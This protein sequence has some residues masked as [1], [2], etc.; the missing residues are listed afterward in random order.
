MNLSEF[1]IKIK[2]SLQLIRCNISKQTAD[3]LDVP[4]DTMLSPLSL[5]HNNNHV[6]SLPQHT[7]A[8][9]KLPNFIEIMSS[10]KSRQSSNGSNVDTVPSDTIP[11]D[12]SH[13]ETESNPIA[14]ETN[15]TYETDEQS[16]HAMDL[17]TTTSLIIHG[18]NGNHDTETVSAPTDANESTIGQYIAKNPN[19][20]PSGDIMNMDIIFEN[21]SIEEDETIGTTMSDQSN[22]ETTVVDAPIV[23]A[24]SE[25][26]PDNM[27]KID[28]IQYE[29]ITVASDKQCDDNETSDD[30]SDNENTLQIVTDD[31]ETVEE[32]EATTIPVI[33]QGYAD[34]NYVY[35]STQN[36]MVIMTCSNLDVA[37]EIETI[38]ESG[39]AVD[40]S[41][42][43]IDLGPSND[44]IDLSESSAVIHLSES[45]GA[46]VPPESS[47]YQATKVE[48]ELEVTNNN[49]IITVNEAIK[50]EA[51]AIKDEIIQPTGAVQTM[52]SNRNRKRKVVP[53][54]AN[55][56]RF[57]SSATKSKDVPS[58]IQNDSESSTKQPPTTAPSLPLSSPPSSSTIQ[59]EASSIDQMSSLDIKTEDQHPGVKAETEQ[60]QII[61]DNDNQTNDNDND[62]NNQDRSFM[63]SLVVVESQDPNDPNRTIH[64][65]YVVDPD[66]NEMSEKPLDL[67]DH[68]I[69]RIRFGLSMS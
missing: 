2:K 65:V 39:E 4:A 62:D 31:S 46:D 37:S 14:I 49:E 19:L 55:K 34:E 10:Q 24:I 17:S 41:T 69:Q 52:D 68:V 1:N 12:V 26:Q 40:L 29:I 54:L 57:R 22:I 61:A 66:T 11:P 3:I 60:E 64:E 35:T 44:G 28:G 56:K 48:P 20:T 42:T 18:T 30:D 50:H 25:S 21:V 33:S 36:E 63:D 43:A 27:V 58:K 32:V 13:I 47:T 8:T 9:H 23:T 5:N 53:V 51:M 67:P 7:Y 45:I 15:G 16:Q 6:D 38:G 59:I